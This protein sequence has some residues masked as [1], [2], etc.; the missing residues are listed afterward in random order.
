MKKRWKNTFVIS[1]LVAS[2]FMCGNAH[3]EEIEVDQD[4][5]LETITGEENLSFENGGYPELTLN[6]PMTVNLDG[7]GSSKWVAS[8]NV[9]AAAQYEFTVTGPADVDCTLAWTYSYAS[10]VLG[11]GVNGVTKY[12]S[13][14]YSIP[15]DLQLTSSIAGS[16]TITVKESDYY[17]HYDRGNS[18]GLIECEPN[19]TKTLTVKPSDNTDQYTYKWQEQVDG[20]WTDL[21]STG[22]IYTLNPPKL[23]YHNYQCIV[24][25]NKHAAETASFKVYATDLSLRYESEVEAR[26]GANVTLSVQPVTSDGQTPIYFQWYERDAGGWPLLSNVLSTDSTLTVKAEG[27]KYYTCFVTQ[28]NEAGTTQKRADFTVNGFDLYIAD[29]SAPQGYQYIETKTGQSFTIQS[30]IKSYNNVTPISYS[31]T[32]SEEDESTEEDRSYLGV[33]GEASITTSFDEP[34]TYYVFCTAEQGGDKCEN[35]FRVE[36]EE[37]KQSQPDTPKT[38]TNQNPQNVT[39]PQS[40]TTTSQDPVKTEK[41]ELPNPPKQV[42]ST[43]GKAKIKITA[44][45]VGNISGY[46]IRYKTGKGKWKTIRVSGNK[47][48]NKTIKKLKRRTKYKV[49]VRTYNDTDKGR[50]YSKSWSKT[51]SVKTK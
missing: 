37:V 38:P 40:Q 43:G 11:T 9:P 4:M 42:K 16:Y 27:M 45:K 5:M 18:Y 6:Q 7:S 1:I 34:G 33:N 49:Q 25:G 29:E 28:G 2:I 17:L 3:A 51:V 23:G 44:K 48:L 12:L 10:E 47:K 21:S 41:V 36:V 8:F 30:Y 19:L 24:T 26:Y 50:Q 35:R 15:V 46:E 13:G 14:E 22:N 32:Y 39:P 20:V 31:W